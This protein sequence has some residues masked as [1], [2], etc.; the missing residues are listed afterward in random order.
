MLREQFRH[1]RRGH[2]IATENPEQPAPVA[3]ADG[4]GGAAEEVAFEA[5]VDKLLASALEEQEREQ[6]AF[7]R[8]LQSSRDALAA[9]RTEL[10]L[11]RAVV[12]GRE[13]AVVDLL[14]ARL[15]T[16]AGAEAVASLQQRIEALEG[17]QASLK[18]ALSVKLDAIA[19]SVEAVEWRTQEGLSALAN[20]V[21][22]LEG[23]FTEHAQAVVE[24]LDTV[25]RRTQ[26]AA[27]SNEAT[28]RSLG[29]SLEARQ[30][31]VAESILK[32][33]D[34]IGRIMQVVQSRLARAASELAVAQGS[35]FARLSEREERLE[36]QRDQI[37]SDLLHEFAGITKHRERGRIGAALVEA[38][39]NRRLRRDAGRT[40]RPDDDN[41]VAPLESYGVGAPGL[42]AG[43]PEAPDPRE[44]RWGRG[45]KP[46]L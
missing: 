18:K 14:D 13:Q 28:L 19:R 22:E 5:R 10:D 1:H 44:R 41:E 30:Q 6:Q 37:L 42:P 3:A 29:E 8:V 24:H 45:N 12:E 32:A 34:P 21:G 38:D 15:A 9:V 7:M 20:R 23:S 36:R 31:E 39:E 27:S 16:A 40:R 35:L 17:E 25:A 4:G 2:A 26:L 11:L 43:A 46:A 33:L